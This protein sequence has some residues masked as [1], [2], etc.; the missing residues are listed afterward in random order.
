V[1]EVEWKGAL[2]R[3]AYGELS[4]KEVLTI[5]K[6]FGPMEVI[7]FE[8]PGCCRGQLSLS[9]T[10]EGVKAIT[11]FHLEVMAEKGQGHGR[12]TL[13]WL[14]RIFKGSLVVEDPGVILVRNAD[15]SSLLFWVKMFREGLV[16][17]ID[18]EECFLFTNISEKELNH[19][20]RN[21]RT[22][23]ANAS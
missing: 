1:V 8:R 10:S 15:Q 17:G 6:G 20:E 14:K 3:A 11:L 13:S 4:L 19:I 21:I 7:Q 18:C 2:W 22:N 5:L 9:L 16:D 12:E 23:L